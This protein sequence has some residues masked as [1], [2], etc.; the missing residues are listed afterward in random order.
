M[1]VVEHHFFPLKIFLLLYCII[2]GTAA[3]I[4]ICTSQGY[5]LEFSRHRIVGCC[6]VTCADAKRITYFITFEFKNNPLYIVE[7]PDDVII[8]NKDMELQV[9]Q[10]T[11]KF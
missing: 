11:R 8:L 10:L 2:T 1:I 3:E 7:S 6:K 5:V 9:R 4:V